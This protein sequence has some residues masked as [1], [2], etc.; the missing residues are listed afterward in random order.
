M[1]VCDNPE[2]PLIIA[3]LELPGIKRDHLSIR[4]ENGQLIIEGERKRPRL[5]MRPLETRTT[6]M[7]SEPTP[8]EDVEYVAPG[9]YPIRELKYGKFCRII[10]LPPRV[11]VSPSGTLFCLKLTRWAKHVRSILVE[12]LLTISWLRDPSISVVGQVT[13]HPSLSTVTTGH[14]TSIPSALWPSA[15]YSY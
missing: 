4:V 9:L 12:G 2:S 11:H 6:S 5:H 3:I 7:S 8:E 14:S 13:E 1:D 10:S 15:S